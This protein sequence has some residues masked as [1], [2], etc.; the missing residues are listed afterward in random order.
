[1]Q[2][3]PSSGS[4]PNTPKP[5]T[6]AGSPGSGSTQP[7]P[8]AEIGEDAK[9]LGTKAANRLHSEVDA[10]KETAVDQAKSVS[11]AIEK[12]TGELD[13]NAPD[14]LKSALRQ[15]AQKVQAFAETI[16]QK[17]SR[18]LMRDAQDFARN[19]P[20][21][22]LAA[23]AAIGFAAARVFKAGAE[24]QPDIGGGDRPAFGQL[25]NQP[26]PPKVASPTGEFA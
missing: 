16:E 4:T 10:R 15:G 25:G 20:G 2:Q 9:Q 18:A 3:P 21:T 8:A 5:T 22:F 24:T 26:T 11:S 23:C 12:V 6:T 1:M 7:G 19:N 14:W 13:Q 17:D